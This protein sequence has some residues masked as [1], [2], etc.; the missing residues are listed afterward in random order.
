MAKALKIER[1]AAHTAP[2]SEKNN[3][4]IN[5]ESLQIAQALKQRDALHQFF[6]AAL[7]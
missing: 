4:K 3:T 1:G 6:F 5:P 7:G 2:L